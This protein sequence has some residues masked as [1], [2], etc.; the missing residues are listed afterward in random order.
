MSFFGKVSPFSRS[1][2][3]GLS[4]T[5]RNLHVLF[6]SSLRHQGGE[7]RV[8]HVMFTKGHPP[9]LYSNRMNRPTI[10]EKNVLNRGA[11]DFRILCNPNRTKTKRTRHVTRIESLSLCTLLFRHLSHVRVLSRKK[12]GP[13]QRNERRVPRPL[14]LVTNVRRPFSRYS[15]RDNFSSGDSREWLL[16]VVVRGY[17]SLSDVFY[18]RGYATHEGQAIR[19]LGR[20]SSHRV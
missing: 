6:Q 13:I 8:F 14:N 7:T 10:L 4:N 9:N 18:G 11:A 2:V 15:I 1:L 19:S 16:R 3:G 20:E 12:R 17:Q 5:S